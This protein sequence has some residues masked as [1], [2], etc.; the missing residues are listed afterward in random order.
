MGKHWDHI[1]N[2]SFHWLLSAG[3]NKS[4]PPPPPPPQQHTHPRDGSSVANYVFS[5][6]WEVLNEKFCKVQGMLAMILNSVPQNVVP[7]SGRILQ[8][9]ESGLSISLTPWK[10][11]QHFFNILKVAS[12]PMEK[13]SFGLHWPML[14]WY[15]LSCNCGHTYTVAN[16]HIIKY[17]YIYV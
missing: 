11:P 12:A 9:L 10:S 17:I 16:I 5:F 15:L 6:P 2:A 8:H 4:P 13:A 7:V 3:H 1:S 14:R